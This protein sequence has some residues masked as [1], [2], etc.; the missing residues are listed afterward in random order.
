MVEGEWGKCPVSCR[1]TAV[2]FGPTSQGALVR[3]LFRKG[4]YGKFIGKKEK[5]SMSKCA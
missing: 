4:Y 2:L 1:S 5:S 3:A